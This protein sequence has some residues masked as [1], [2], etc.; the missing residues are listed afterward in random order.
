MDAYRVVYPLVSKGSARSNAS[1][2]ITNANI[3]EYIQESKQALAL[4]SN[5]DRTWKR[6]TL[7]EVVERSMELQPLHKKGKEVLGKCEF[8]GAAVIK[9]ISEMNRMDGDY[10]V[11]QHQPIQES[12]SDRI[13]RLCRTQPD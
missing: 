12:H 1:R 8:D 7:I 11:A 9:A 3:S 10:G 2:L 13:R 4:G 6:H 5:H